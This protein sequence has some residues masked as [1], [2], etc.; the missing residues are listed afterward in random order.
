MASTYDVPEIPFSSNPAIR[1]DLAPVDRPDERPAVENQQ[2][3]VADQTEVSPAADP[4]H[5]D[6]APLQGEASPSPDSGAAESTEVVAAVRHA[7][8]QAA[9]PASPTVISYPTTP[10]AS[11]DFGLLTA[12]DGFQ[13][14]SGGVPAQQPELPPDTH[15]P[16]SAGV[17]AFAPQ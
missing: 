17:S 13:P 6:D 11:F 16:A 9:A 1:L 4:V 7:T 14:M 2:P 12:G 3:I 10:F 8:P 15:A 5:N